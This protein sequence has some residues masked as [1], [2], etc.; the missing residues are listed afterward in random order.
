MY[1]KRKDFKRL[2]I[3]NPYVTYGIDQQVT[4]SDFKQLKFLGEGSFGKVEAYALRSNPG[5]KYAIKTIP[6]SLI[7]KYNMV[8]QMNQELRILY[9]LNHFNIAKLYSHF[10]DETFIYM[11]QEYAELGDLFRFIEKFPRKRLKEKKAANLIKQLLEALKYIHSNGIMHR[12]IKPENIFLGKG[13]IVKLGDFGWSSFVSNKEKRYTFCGTPDYLAPE[14]ID[15]S[16]GHG[17]SVDVWAVGI[18]AFELV[19]GLPP[20]HSKSYEAT[21]ENIKKM[22]YRLDSDFSNKAKDF[23]SKILR[24]NPRQRPSAASLLEHPWLKD[25]QVKRIRL[26][27]TKNFYSHLKKQVYSKPKVVV[28]AQNRKLGED[29]SKLLRKQPYQINPQEQADKVKVEPDD[30]E[31]MK[32]DEEFV[33]DPEELIKSVQPQSIIKGEAIKFYDYNFDQDAH[34]SSYQHKDQVKVPQEAGGKKIALNTKLKK[35]QVQKYKLDN[36]KPKSF[37]KETKKQVPL[38]QIKKNKMIKLKKGGL[39]GQKGLDLKEYQSNNVQSG[40][41]GIYYTNTTNKYQKG[42]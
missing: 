31:L 21:L 34:E 30:L 22:K 6:K 37:Q 33:M 36:L 39:K 27:D 1:H 12:D 32:E 25:L 2:L 20:F 3:Q 9:R 38:T 5:R 40:S 13:E 28:K 23:I 41:N 26:G 18:M 11:V 4:I 29:F 14:M 7:R 8:R 17:N 35:K 10:E 24:R 19:K 16:V 15:Q 42:R